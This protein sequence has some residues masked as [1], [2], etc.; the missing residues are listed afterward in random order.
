MGYGKGV[1]AP[2]HT[3]NRTKWETLPPNRTLAY[4]LLIAHGYAVK[5]YREQFQ[6]QQKGTIGIPLDSGWFEPYT[7]TQ[8]DADAVKRTLDVRLALSPC[9]R[10]GI[11]PRLLQGWFAHPVYLGYYPEALKKQ[12]GS[13]LPDFTAE[14]I[15]V[16]KGSSDFFGLNHYTTHLVS[17]GGDDEFNGY[18]KQTHKKPD[19]T[20]LGTQDT[21]ADV[22]WLQTYAPGFRK[23][24][25]TTNI[26]GIFSSVVQLL[27]YSYKKYGKP[28]MKLGF[29][30]MNKNSK[31]IEEALNDA[32]REEYYRDYTKAMLQAV[33]EDSVDV[34]GYLGWSLLDNFGWCLLFSVDTC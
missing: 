30:V 25:T 15:V 18:V 4:I 31:T 17:E 34:K 33:I 26:Y 2:G 19:G 3:S 8:E 27:G 23:V 10:K 32:D 11:L 22:N 20:D 13:R 6:P 12:C 7:H 1:I 28:I 5:L 29:A 16:V 21:A 14:E 9:D 24:R